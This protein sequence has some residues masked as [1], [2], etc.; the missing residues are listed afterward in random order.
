[1]LCITSFLVAQA[2]TLGMVEKT[3]LSPQIQ[4]GVIER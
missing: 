4:Y 3:R 1:M 2:L